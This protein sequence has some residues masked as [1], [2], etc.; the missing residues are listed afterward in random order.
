MSKFLS[1]CI[2]A[3]QYELKIDSD[4]YIGKTIKNILMYVITQKGRPLNASIENRRCY[5]CKKGFI[6][7]FRN[8]SLRLLDRCYDAFSKSVIMPFRIITPF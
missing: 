5:A 2:N 1:T 7:T 3:I 4:L 6:V 8:V